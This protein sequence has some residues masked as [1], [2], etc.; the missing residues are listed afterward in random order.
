MRYTFILTI[1]IYLFSVSATSAQQRIAQQ[2]KEGPVTV[3]MQAPPVVAYTDP[4]DPQE[5]MRIRAENMAKKD[6]YNSELK[7][8]QFGLPA[9]NYPHQIRIELLKN[10]YGL[11]YRMM[12]CVP[13]DSMRYYNNMADQ[14]LQRKYGSDFWQKVEQQV[15]STV[16]ATGWKWEY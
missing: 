9:R 7:Y 13:N 2:V 15:D 3:R 16:K 5:R 12:G 11:D 14:L 6:N 1:A 10:K 8:Y 4:I